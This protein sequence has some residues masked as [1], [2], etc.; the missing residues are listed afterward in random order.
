MS[1][2]T[3]M[4]D[5]DGYDAWNQAL[6]SAADL[7]LR[8]LE[9]KLGH[10]TEPVFAATVTLPIMVVP[11]GSLWQMEF[12]EDGEPIHAPIQVS[13]VTVFR[14]H[15]VRRTE[16]IGTPFY[17]VVRLPNIHFYTQTGLREF[18]EIV[19]NRHAMFWEYA[20]P[21][22]Q[23]EDFKNASLRSPEPAKINMC[24][25]IAHLTT[26]C[27]ALLL[28]SA[29][30][31]PRPSIIVL[32]CDDLGYGDLSCFAHPEIRTPQSRSTRPRRR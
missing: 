1:G 11:D 18:V 32:L 3:V 13:H 8:G 12:G 31:A 23:I 30:T 22:E 10:P 15:N 27:L 17:R 21:E 25:P 14:D 20:F 24:R 6:G 19:S 28:A 2:Y 16:K 7:A 29:A 9:F 4:R 5:D 26:V